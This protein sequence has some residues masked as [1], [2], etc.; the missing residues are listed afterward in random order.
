MFR[1]LSTQCWKGFKFSDAYGKE[2]AC[3]IRE[4][5]VSTVQTKENFPRYVNLKR[6][7][8]SNVKTEENS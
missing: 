3:I 8:Q 7:F 6:N 5:L 4:I 1:A 2:N